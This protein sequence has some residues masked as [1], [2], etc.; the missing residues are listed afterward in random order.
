MR[1]LLLLV[2]FAGLSLAQ[3]VPPVVMLPNL[4]SN[5]SQTLVASASARCNNTSIAPGCTQLTAGNYYAISQGGTGGVHYDAGGNLFIGVG[6]STTPPLQVPGSP[7]A[8]DS[9]IQ[10]APDGSSRNFLSF[11]VPTTPVCT[12]A[13][14]STLWLGAYSFLQPFF[15][16]NPA[17]NGL[18]VVTVNSAQLFYWNPGANSCTCVQGAASCT[19]PGLLG[20]GFVLTVAL[21]ELTGPGV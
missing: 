4:P 21:I 16:F 6:T 11:P 12:I 5:V 10:M 7:G 13:S 17:T 2:A 20:D 1:P 3:T 8:L 19:S 15:S 14:S 18:Y 9:L